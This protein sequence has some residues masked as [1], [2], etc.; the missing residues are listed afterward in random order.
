MQKK[1]HSLYQKMYLFYGYITVK[2]INKCVVQY[3]RASSAP[4]K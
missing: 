2:Y 1:Q 3:N 4:K